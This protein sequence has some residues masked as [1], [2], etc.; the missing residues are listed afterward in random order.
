[1]IAKFIFCDSIFLSVFYVSNHEYMCWS[2][3]GIRVA[4]MHNK[5]GKDTGRTWIFEY[6][7]GNENNFFEVIIL[8]TQLF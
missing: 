2:R 1:M 8:L 7:K 4:A 5:E 3:K 6:R